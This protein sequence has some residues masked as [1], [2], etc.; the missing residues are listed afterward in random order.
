MKRKSTS[1]SEHLYGKNATI[2]T[3]SKGPMLILHKKM[4]YYLLEVSLYHEML[5]KVPKAAIL[6]SVCFDLGRD[7]VQ[8]AQCQ[9]RQIQPIE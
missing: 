8:S 7:S 4:P 6:W 9:Q 2:A 1:R 5:K 3:F